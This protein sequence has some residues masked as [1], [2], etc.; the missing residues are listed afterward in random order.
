MDASTGNKT[1]IAQGNVHSIDFSNNK[2]LAPLALD[3]RPM[4]VLHHPTV[5]STVYEE[6]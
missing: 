2:T 6:S 5:T 4:C 1:H 3:K